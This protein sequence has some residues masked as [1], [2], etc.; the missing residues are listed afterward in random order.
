[1]MDIGL[2][3]L[4]GFGEIPRKRRVA[5]NA[6]VFGRSSETACSENNIKVMKVVEFFI[7]I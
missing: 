7:V 2:E 1:M 4:G 5:G 6:G 3:L